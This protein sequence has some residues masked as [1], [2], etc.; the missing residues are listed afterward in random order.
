[1][2]I[3]NIFLKNILPTALLSDFSVI[4]R[5][6]VKA[7]PEKFGLFYLEPAMTNDEIR[8]QLGWKFRK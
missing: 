4:F 8:T 2:M 6:S 5:H 3:K 1:M 7:H